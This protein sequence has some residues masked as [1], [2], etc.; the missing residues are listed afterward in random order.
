MT[1]ALLGAHMLRGW[2][3]TKRTLYDATEA[4][5]MERKG[6]IREK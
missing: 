1:E 5:T 3:Q 6:T 2:K 4:N